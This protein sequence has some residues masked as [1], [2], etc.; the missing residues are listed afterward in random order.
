VTRKKGSVAPIFKKGRKDDPGNYQPVN[1]ISV[2]G[3]ITEQILLEAI[4]RHVEE[5]EVTWDIQHGFTKGRSCLT[6]LVTFC[7][8]VIASVDKGRATNVI[9]LDFSNAFNMVPHKILLSKLERYGLDRMD[10]ELIMR[11]YPEGYG[12]RL[13]V[14]M[15]ITDKWC[16]SDKLCGAADTQEMECYPERL[17]QAQ[18]EA[19]VSHM[20]FNKSKCKV[21]TCV[22]ATPTTSTSWWLW[23]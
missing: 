21:Y 11:Y 13:N 22:T 9:Y 4:L 14:Q 17:R 20:R 16:L 19:Q 15:K 10:G 18:A 7:E 23:E 12:Q 2:L 3:K 6:N 8:G 1:L 5:R